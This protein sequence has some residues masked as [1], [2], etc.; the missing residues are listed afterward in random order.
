VISHDEHY[1]N[2]WM[3]SAVNQQMIDAEQPQVSWFV[4]SNFDGLQKHF[5][6]LA[7]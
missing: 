2:A 4:I 3:H 1:G 5:S 6:A 7:C